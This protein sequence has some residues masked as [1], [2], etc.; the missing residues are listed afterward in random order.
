MKETTFSPKIMKENNIL[1]IWDVIRKKFIQLTPEEWVRQKCIFLLITEKN[2][3]KGLFQIEKASKYVQ[4]IKR[5]DILVYDTQGEPFLLIEC[6]AQHIALDIDA[7]QQLL[8]YH[9]IF[10]TPYL[11]LYN[12]IDI[13]IWK[14]DKNTNEYI[15]IDELPNGT[16]EIMDYGL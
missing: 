3:A 5:T 15:Q 12:D 4:K 14:F 1:Y 8:T 9:A 2:Y 11:A 6:K 7:F 10:P 13:K 16:R